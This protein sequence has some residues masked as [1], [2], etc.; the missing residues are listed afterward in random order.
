MEDSQHPPWQRHPEKREV[1][2]GATSAVASR[3]PSTSSPIRSSVTSSPRDPIARPHARAC[4]SRWWTWNLGR[5]VLEN[6]PSLRSQSLGMMRHE[7]DRFQEDWKHVETTH[8]ILFGLYFQCSM[9]VMMVSLHIYHTLPLF[10]INR[11]GELVTA[12]QIVR[13]LDVETMLMSSD[14][15]YRQE[16]IISHQLNFG[17]GVYGF[18]HLFGWRFSQPKLPWKKISQRS[19]RHQDIQGDIRHPVDYLVDL[20]ET[21]VQIDDSGCLKGKGHIVNLWD[22]KGTHLS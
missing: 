15:W 3:V 16:L 12:V 4:A 1:I 8:Q 6:C 14:R 11:R 18:S 17:H 10:V 19:L 7:I 5:R 13:S 2:A 22:R 21:K 9:L 20:I